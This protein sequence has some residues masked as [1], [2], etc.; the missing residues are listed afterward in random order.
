MDNISGFGP[1]YLGSSPSKPINE[2]IL[3]GAIIYYT[4]K[5]IE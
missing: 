2:I 4:I 1:L 5:V 3:K